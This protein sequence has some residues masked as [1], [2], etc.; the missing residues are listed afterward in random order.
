MQKEVFRSGIQVR[1]C[2]ARGGQ[3]PRREA[4]QVDQKFRLKKFCSI[5]KGRS[6]KRCHHCFW[7]CW[8]WPWDRCS[9]RH[10]RLPEDSSKLRYI[11]VNILQDYFASGVK[12]ISIL[13]FLYKSAK[14]DILKTKN[15]T[16]SFSWQIQR[17]CERWEGPLKKPE[18]FSFKLI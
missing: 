13:F 3:L 14:K 6:W 16:D 9:T 2:R 11:I 8:Q 15:V 10:G 12:F 4:T 5:F 18:S 7:R 17:A 1:G